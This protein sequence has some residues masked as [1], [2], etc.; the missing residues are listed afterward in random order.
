M[1]SNLICIAI[2]IALGALISP[3]TAIAQDQVDIGLYQNNNMLEVRVKP[4]ADFDGIFSA[5][6]FTIKWDRTSGAALGN[7]TQEGPAAQYVAINRSGNA[8]E[9]GSYNYQVYAGFGNLTL[10]SQ[11]A[12][13]TAGEEYVIATIPVSGR[14]EFELVNDAWT[15]EPA[16]NANYYVSLGGHDKTGSIYKSITTAEEDASVVIQPNPNQGLFTFSFVNRN[17]SDITV[18]VIN[19]LGQSV[20]TDAIPA[21][22]GTYRKEMDIT[23]MS[24]GVYYLK[25]KRGEFTSVH[26]IVYR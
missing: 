9:H 12:A 26:K 4:Q 13:W 15:G 3:A 17:A 8:H 2:G 23:S 14:S 7:L 19:A 21:F 22:E 11:S 10:A 1:K 5:V 25:V 24:N 20:F 18:D 16:H 6:V